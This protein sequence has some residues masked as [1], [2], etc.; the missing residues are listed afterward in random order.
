MIKQDVLLELCAKY[1]TNENI[2]KII[3]DEARWLLCNLASLDG[4]ILESINPY[5]M[6][7]ILYSL[8]HNIDEKD[9]EKAEDVNK[10]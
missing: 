5:I 6:N 1:I 8:I 2:D 10:F 4:P 9:K 7:N 3:K